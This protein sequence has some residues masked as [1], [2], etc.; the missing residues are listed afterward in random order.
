MP[1]YAV[2]SCGKGNSYGHPHEEVLSRLY[3]AD[4]TLFRTDLQGD[5]VCTS[6]GSSVKFSVSRNPNADVYNGRGSNP[7]LPEQ[8][9]PPENPPQQTQPEDTPTGADYVLNTNSMKFHYAHCEWAQKISDR[10][11]QDY[12]GSREDL[13]EQGYTPCG[14]CN[15]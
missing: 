5:I 11:R 6:N 7:S 15:P 12:T 9:D 10:N 8:T 4:V 1:Q 14:G 3:D 2:I 13:I